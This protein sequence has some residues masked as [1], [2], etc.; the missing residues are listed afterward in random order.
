MD[1]DAGGAAGNL[2]AECGITVPPDHETSSPPADHH[3]ILFTFS[4]RGCRD[5]VLAEPGQPGVEST[6]I[7]PDRSM[8][9]VLMQDYAF[10]ERHT[11]NDDESFLSEQASSCI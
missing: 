4:V 11:P 3:S 8:A 7:M 5:V 1:R 10:I 6:I 2:V 9:T